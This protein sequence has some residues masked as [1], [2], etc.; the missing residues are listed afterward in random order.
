MKRTSRLR[1]PLAKP[2]WPGTVELEREVSKLGPNFETAWSRRYPVRLIRAILIDNA[3]RPA[4]KL[5]ASPEVFGEDRLEGVVGPLIFAV[6]HASHLDTPLVLSMLPERFRHRCV[7]AAGADYFFDRRWKAYIWSG[8]LAAIPIERQK[9][10]RRSAEVSADL[11]NKG[12]NLLIFPEGGRTPDGLAQ[13]FK[14]GVAQLAQRSTAPIV[15][16]YLEG[17][18][19][20]FGKNSSRPKAGKTRMN[21]GRPIY[22]RE[23]EDPRALTLRVERAVDELAY[24]L[25]VDWWQAKQLASNGELPHLVPEDRASWIADWE[26]TKNL[27]KRSKAPLWPKYFGSRRS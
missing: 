18:Y 19:E 11:L 9:V 22:R 10:N 6:N 24:E 14:G 23:G 16:I 27:P 20:I 5:L 25:H 17:T 4:A 3:V 21:F 26:R 8:L 7:V 15:P 1:F 2:S 12:W 13:G